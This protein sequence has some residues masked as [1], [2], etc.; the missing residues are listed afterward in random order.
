MLTKNTSVM[1]LGGWVAMATLLG[2]AVAQLP[3]QTPAREAGIQSVLIKLEENQDAFERYVSEQLSPQMSKII[4]TFEQNV[5][6][7][8]KVLEQL[9]NDPQN[10][11]LRAQYED[12][13]SSAIAQASAILDEFGHQQGPAFQAID[14]MGKTLQDAGRAFEANIAAGTKEVAEFHR[15]GDAVRTNLAALA[16]R[17][18]HEL[19]TGQSL[20]D[21]VDLDSR[22]LQADLETAEANEKIAQMKTVDAQ[23]A[24]KAL[25]AQ[26]RDLKQ[27]RGDLQVAFRQ[28]Q[29]QHM[30]LSNLAGMKQ[31]RL[32]SQAV[33]ARLE[34]MRKVVSTRKTDLGQIGKLVDQV[35][36]RDLAQAGP[37]GSK[38]ERKP[39]IQPSSDILRAY[40]P[41]E[42][43]EELRA[44]KK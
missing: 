3:A 10:K 7:A 26:A 8:G 39:T 41:I 19:K 14:S 16:K 31:S 34:A 37:S 12:S 18:E 1:V 6:R 23:E 44:A 29:G 5:E 9:R 11:Q 43:K 36:K 17:Y 22:L 4:S 25:E 15:Q 33:S 38:A 13:L 27:L 28:S 24:V 2:E 35:V 32:Q 30:L 42:K 21:E 20:P 40:L